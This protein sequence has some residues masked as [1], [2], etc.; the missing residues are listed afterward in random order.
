F[1]NYSRVPLF[2]IS[3]S[4][5]AVFH[6]GAT[7]KT[8]QNE[9]PFSAL[10]PSKSRTVWIVNTDTDPVTV[11]NPDRARYVRFPGMAHFQNET[12]PSLIDD[13]WTIT[14][15][16]EPVEHLGKSTTM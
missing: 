4:F 16:H 5:Q 8:E 9:F 3:F 12:L 2:D 13:S 10:E 7:R 11:V 15:N 1:T 6:N 14:R